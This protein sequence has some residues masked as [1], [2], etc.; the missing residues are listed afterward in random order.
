MAAHIVP[1]HACNVSREVIAAM[2]TFVE[3]LALSLLNAERSFLQI[4]C[5]IG[6]DVVCA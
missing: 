6:R 5:H 1:S 3:A 4:Y 2:E